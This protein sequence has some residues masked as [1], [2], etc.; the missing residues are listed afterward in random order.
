MQPELIDI[1]GTPIPDFY[2]TGGDMGTVATG[3]LMAA[4]GAMMGVMMIFYLV[5]IAILIISQWKVFSKAGKPGWAALIPFYNIYVL[6][7]VAGM[8]GWWLLAL[9]VPFLNL[10]A[11]ILITHKISEAFGHGVGFTLGLLFLPIIFWPIFA[12]GSSEYQPDQASAK[13][14]TKTT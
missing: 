3:G 14:Q 6:I 8:S 2:A 1:T 9:F 12:F 5:V 4:F 13:D 11:I 7:K 10:I